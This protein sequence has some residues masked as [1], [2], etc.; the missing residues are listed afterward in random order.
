MK[1]I[2]QVLEG[3]SINVSH[4]LNPQTWMRLVWIVVFSLINSLL[5]KPAVSMV[6]VFQFVVVLFTGAPN[7]HLLRF[8]HSL[9]DYTRQI[10]RFTCFNSDERP[11]PLS[12][13]PNS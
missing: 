10:V 4:A 11:F 5:V 3:T 9:A 7:A 13:W 12:P 1:D 8:S 6:A 2:K